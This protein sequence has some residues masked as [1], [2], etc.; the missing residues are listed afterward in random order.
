MLRKTK[1]L[2]NPLTV[3]DIVFV[4]GDSMFEVYNS[5]SFPSAICMLFFSFAD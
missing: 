2:Y 4:L 1:K 3:L 5:F